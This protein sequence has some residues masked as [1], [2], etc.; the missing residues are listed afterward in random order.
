MSRT[1]AALAVIAGLAAAVLGAWWL[2]GLAALAA[3]VAVQSSLLRQ[4]VARPAR[5]R[6]GA[7]RAAGRLAHGLGRAARATGRALARAVGGLVGL[8]AFYAVLTP[9]GLGARLLGV[10]L[11]PE[12]EWRH[13]PAPQRAAHRRSVVKAPT[14]RRGAAGGVGPRLTWRTAAALLAAG[15]LAAT[16]LPRVLDRS[17]DESAIPEQLRGATY[18][19]IDAPALADSAWRNDA[20]AEFAE[21]SG[22]LTYT[23]YVGN[24]LRDYEGR[25]VNIADR[26]RASY[27]SALDA[28]P[29]DVWF[30]GGSTMFGFSAQRDEHTIPSEVVRLAEADGVRVRAHNFGS[31]GYV[32]MQETALAAQLLA[33]GERPDLMVFYDG[34]ND[35]ALQFQQA[36]GGVGIPG[37]PS[38][39]SAFAYRGLLEGQ[40]TGSGQP[41]SPLGTVPSPGRPPQAAA[42]IAAITEVYGRGI[43]L[44]T[45]L[46]RQ[47]GV[48][49]A[50]F[51]QPD[52]FNTAELAPGEQEVVERL[53]M[54]EFQYDAVARISRA[55]VEALPRTVIDLS[56]A[57]SATDAP[58]LTDQAH[59][60]EL[61]A[62]LV[63]EAMYAEL[64]PAL[65][66][67]AGGEPGA[68]GTIGP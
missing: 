25:Y 42:V 2:A 6:P 7:R 9:L 44:A 57:F 55:L 60:N 21:A 68:S 12:G 49:V 43:D 47:Y 63:A 23:S 50:H 58:V 1:A 52:L 5:T 39:L 30:F 51:W 35:L 46:G 40:L 11:L 48:P 31:P 33:A 61:G 32:N 41:P 27:R 4:P 17:P 18:N 34:I 62:R 28:A 53:G 8:V 54:D 66:D 13:R 26:Q 15:A 3:L 20:G 45:A 56:D 37:D 19:A 59:T 10:R 24:S 22:G 67:L 38:D 14:G 64:A 65:A 36:F 16:L 29:V